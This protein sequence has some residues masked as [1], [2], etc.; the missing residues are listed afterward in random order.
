LKKVRLLKVLVAK[1]FGCKMSGTSFVKIDFEIPGQGRSVYCQ[2]WIGKG[3][4][5]DFEKNLRIIG[6][7]GEIFVDI[8][9][10]HYTVLDEKGKKIKEDKLLYDYEKSFLLSALDF[11]KTISQIPG[12]LPFE[13]AK[14]ILYILD[15]ARWRSEPRGKSPIYKVGSS[16]SEIEKIIKTKLNN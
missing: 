12:A 3:V 10:F 6:T 9:N 13:A 14:E 11:K 2:S 15:E 7:K 16:V 4:G 5:N 8:K 1:Y